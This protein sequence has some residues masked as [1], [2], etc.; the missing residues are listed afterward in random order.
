MY[1]INVIYCTWP[2]CPMILF[3][4]FILSSRSW[5][6]VD[7][8]RFCRVFTLFIYWNKVI[9]SSQMI[10]ILYFLTHKSIYIE[11]VA[12]ISKSKSTL[13]YRSYICHV[14]SNI[15]RKLNSGIVGHFSLF[16]SECKYTWT[17]KLTCKTFFWINFNS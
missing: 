17:L 7:V 5:S 11:V 6:D 8:E 16:R 15:G 2:T 3:D 9:N 1:A 10:F 12:E 14:N 13:I 4:E